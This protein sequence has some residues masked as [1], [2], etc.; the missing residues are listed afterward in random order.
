VPSGRIAEDS[1]VAER[2]VIFDVER[3]Q[4]FARSGVPLRLV[5][6]AMFFI[7]GSINWLA[8]LF[9]L[10]ITTA[11]LVREKGP[12][13]FFAEDRDRMTV[14]LGWIIGI[15]SYF[16][17]LT[18]HLSLDA[19]AESDIRFVV[20]PSGTPT[21]RSALWRIVTS[22]PNVIVFGVF[23]LLALVV[24]VVAGFSIL[25]TGNYPRSLFAYQ[26]AINRWQARLFSYHTSL[27]NQY[28]PFGLSFGRET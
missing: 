6:L 23:G 27:V 10:P 20:V 26:R 18:D 7:P 8:S 28:P 5:V 24:W 11:V 22:L 15:Y 3:P 1:G 2:H 14:L 4:S 19:R 13:R 9:Y 16:A 17:Y 21:P 12:E 25:V